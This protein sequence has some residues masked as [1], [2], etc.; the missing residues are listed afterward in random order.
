MIFFG[1]GSGHH[2][3]YETLHELRVQEILK[4]TKK[5]RMVINNETFYGI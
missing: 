4:R 5:H 1:S 2:E 3:V